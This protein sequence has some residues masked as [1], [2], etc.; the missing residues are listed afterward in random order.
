M[1]DQ[2]DYGFFFYLMMVNDQNVVFYLVLS[3]L[4]PLGRN[5]LI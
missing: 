1:A 4:A 3:L 5:H 2:E